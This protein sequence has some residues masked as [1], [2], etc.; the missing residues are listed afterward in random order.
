LPIFLLVV[1]SAK[2]ITILSAVLTVV[3]AVLVVGFEFASWKRDGVWN[4]YRLSSVIESIKGNREVTYV[5]ASA[6]RLP[7]ELTIKQSLIEWVLG[8]PVIA[9]LMLAVVLHLALYLYLT[10]LEKEASRR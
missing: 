8:I 10:T 1:K 3:C 9:L 5:T 6:H 7:A 2:Q 4:S